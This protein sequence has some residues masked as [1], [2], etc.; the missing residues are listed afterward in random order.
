MKDDLIQPFILRM[1]EASNVIFR[2]AANHVKLV[3]CEG[4]IKTT[5]IERE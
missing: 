5:L 2:N 3:N 1:T 4:K